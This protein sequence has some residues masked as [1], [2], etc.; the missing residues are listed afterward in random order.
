MRRLTV[1]MSDEE[2]RE[3]LEF[4]RSLPDYPSK[5]TAAKSAILSHIR[6]LSNSSPKRPW[7]K[8]SVQDITSTPDGQGLL[9]E[10]AKEEKLTKL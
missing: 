6:S 5:S 1:L 7:R 8:P 4:C 10:Y 9:A 3:F 2:W